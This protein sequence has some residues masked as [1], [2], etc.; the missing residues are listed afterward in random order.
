M[1]IR[2]AVDQE[3]LAGWGVDAEF[4]PFLHTVQPVGSKGAAGFDFDRLQSLRRF[5]HHVDFVART[6]A[7]EVEVGAR[8]SG[9]RRENTTWST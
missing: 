3:G 4:L 7:P 8:P 2:T 5:V 9:Q 6:V 1:A